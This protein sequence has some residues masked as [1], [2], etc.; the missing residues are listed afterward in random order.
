MPLNCHDAIWNFQECIKKAYVEFDINSLRGTRADK[1]YQIN[2]KPILSWYYEVV[3]AKELEGSKFDFRKALDDILFTSDE[4]AYF[5]CNLFIYRPFINNPIKDGHFFV[6]RM[7]YPNNMNLETQR[8]N[9]FTAIVAEKL[10]NFWDRIGD[11]IEAYFKELK[12]KESGVYFCNVMDRIP[13]MHHSSENYKWL[14]NFRNTSYKELNEKRKNFVHYVSA[15]TEF[16]Y[17]HLDASKEFTLLSKLIE[18]RANLPDKY[19][20]QLNN[21]LIGFEKTINFLV[22][23]NAINERRLD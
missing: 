4:V 14:M 8:Y 5:I 11:L 2:G 17:Q 10:Y 13:E 1:R 6:G 9:M 12:I 15:N 22:E 3:R 18:E 21:T 19:L 23:M 7:L 20:A 16:N